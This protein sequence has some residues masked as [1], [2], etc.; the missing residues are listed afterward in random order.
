MVIIN[1]AAVPTYPCGSIGLLVC[2]KDQSESCARP[3]RVLPD[4]LLPQLNYY[5]VALHEAC[6]AR[7]TFVN[8]E[9]D[10]LLQA[11]FHM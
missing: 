3:L 11:P 6:F 5:N 8:R 2:R 10:S 4:S 1:H 9:I 7:P